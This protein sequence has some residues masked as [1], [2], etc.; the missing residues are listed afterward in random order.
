MGGMGRVCGAQDTQ[1]GLRCSRGVWRTIRFRLGG[2]SEVFGFF[3]HWESRLIHANTMVFLSYNMVPELL[4][5]QS[6][7]LTTEESM[8]VS[9]DSL[10]DGPS[11]GACPRGG[12]SYASAQAVLYSAPSWR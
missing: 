2:A 7:L 5:R 3:F 12:T 9:W 4:G 10:L 11:V 8:V 6:E 1:A